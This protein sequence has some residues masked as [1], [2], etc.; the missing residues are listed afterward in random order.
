MKQEQQYFSVVI[1]LYNKKRYIDRTL[2][3]VLSQTYQ[4]FEII[5]VNDGSDDGG[6]A[7]VA[8][9]K[10]KNIRL[11]NQKNNGVS[12]ARNNGIRE[13]KYDFVCLLDSDD[14]WMPEFLQEIAN[15]ISDFPEHHIFSLRHEIVDSDGQMIYPKVQLH[16]NYRGVISDFT[17]LF[18]KSSGLINASSVCLR[19]SYCTE[20]GGFPDGQDQGEDIYLWILY[21][22][23]THFVFYN[24]VG[25]CYFRNS[26]NRSTDRFTMEGLPYHFSYFYGLLNRK[27]FSSKYG[28]KKESELRHYLRKQASA[29]IAQL[30]VLGKPEI[31]AAHRRQLY[32]LNRSTGSLCY[33]IAL[34]PSQALE[35]FKFIRKTRRLSL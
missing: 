34:L 20:L 4:N 9:Y 2:Q 23:N 32:D 6:E 27:D 28:Q 21:S 11:I 31:A 17:R 19:K 12:A 35:C 7:L 15:L 5:V 30:V 13:A 24:K 8:A 10:S 14:A 25:S 29:H 22:L 1:P 16:K 26:I 33:L 3:S 18:A